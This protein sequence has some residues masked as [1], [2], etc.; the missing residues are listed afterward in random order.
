MPLVHR[1]QRAP[2]GTLDSLVGRDGP[3]HPA[4]W[5]CLVRPENLGIQVSP[6]TLEEADFLAIAVTQDK[7]EL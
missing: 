6:V 3:V 1:D 4:I 7:T 5:V 2:V